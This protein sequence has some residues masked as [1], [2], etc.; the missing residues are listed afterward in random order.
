VRL[1]IRIQL[2]REL[3][4][5]LDGVGQRPVRRRQLLGVRHVGVDDP[6]AHPRDRLSVAQPARV[7]DGVDRKRHALQRQTQQLGA[8][9]EL[10]L[11]RQ[12]TDA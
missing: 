10:R 1:Q 11:L 12:R 4:V 5:L 3:P 7:Q 9:R 6:P 8:A 2:A